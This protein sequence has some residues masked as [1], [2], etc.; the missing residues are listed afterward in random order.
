MK[1]KLFLLCLFDK[2]G[3]FGKDW[4]DAG[5]K[6]VCLDWEADEGFR[7][8]I[9][10]KRHDLRD[11]E[12]L[13]NDLDASPPDV[14][15]SFPDC[16]DL[17]VSGALHF[18]GK[19]KKDPNFQINAIELFKTGEKVSERYNIPSFTENPISVAATMY[20]KPDGYFHPYDYGGYLDAGDEHP[21]WPDYIAPRDAYPKNTSAW[22]LNGFELPARKP[23]VVGEGYSKQYKKLGGKSKKTKEIRS[24]TPRGF[25]KACFLHM[26]PVLM[27]KLI[28]TQ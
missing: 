11:L 15:V 17:A 2:S 16:T 13:F 4:A 23:V 1:N 10:Y 22:L 6:V 7:D 25:S 26:E 8:G 28:D 19:R 21:A 20:R 14:V 9:L 12:S 18:K 24:L 27:N 5:H 3:I